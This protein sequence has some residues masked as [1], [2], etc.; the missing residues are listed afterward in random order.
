MLQLRSSRRHPLDV[1]RVACMWQSLDEC[2]LLFDA[3]CLH[4][5]GIA[6]IVVDSRQSEPRVRRFMH[7][8]RRQARY[9]ALHDEANV[10]LNCV[11]SLRI[12]I[13]PQPRREHDA[14]LILLQTIGAPR[15]ELADHA[16]CGR[17]AFSCGRTC[18]GIE[19]PIV[20]RDGPQ[21]RDRTAL[22]FPS[23]PSLE[24]P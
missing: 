1:F 7:E 19:A 24:I 4:T 20:H 18:C 5:P 2:D 23:L 21:P 11:R 15:I 8:S 13:P 17:N 3:P 22:P 6:A 9:R 10:E 16:E 14:D 12:S